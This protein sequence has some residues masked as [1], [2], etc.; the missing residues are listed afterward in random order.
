MAWNF[1]SAIYKSGWDKLAA[2]KKQKYFRQCISVQFNKKFSN[3]SVPKEESK[4][5]GKQA[6]VS[7]ISLPIPPWPSK[8]ILAKSKFFKDNDNQES[9]PNSQ[10]NKPSYT[11]AFK[12]NIQNFLKIKNAFL[13]LSLDKISEIHNVINKSNQKGKPRLNITMKGLSRKQIIFPMGINNIE[14]VIVQ[15]N[16]NVANINRLL[17]SIKSEV[18]VDFICSNIKDI[19]V[20]TSKIATISDYTNSNI[21]EI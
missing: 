1:L 17:K 9:K 13:K 11:Q 12:S 16:A 4:D 6:S 20:M 7:R 10:S 21:T 5:K 14:R 19:V 15:S 2:N 18:S 3:N 8:S